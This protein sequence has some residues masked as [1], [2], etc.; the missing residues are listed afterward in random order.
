[1]LKRFFFFKFAIDYFSHVIFWDSN[2]AEVPPERS[3]LSGDILA[4]HEDLEQL[5]VEFQYKLEDERV[6][7]SFCIKQ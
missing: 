1:M 5:I 2:A 4:S 6:L 3:I 7:T